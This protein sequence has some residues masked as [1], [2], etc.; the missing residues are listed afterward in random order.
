MQPVLHNHWFLLLTVAYLIVSI[1]MAVFLGRVIKVGQH[2]KP[3]SDP[4]PRLSQRRSLD[5][6]HRAAALGSAD[7]HRTPS[8]CRHPAHRSPG[9]RTA[10]I[11]RSDNARG[12]AENGWALGP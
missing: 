3:P 11:L 4:V 12:S 6:F 7:G 5:T 10:G 2:D 1:P 8:A 9:P